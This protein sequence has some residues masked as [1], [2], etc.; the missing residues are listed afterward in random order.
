MATCARRG[1]SDR[2]RRHESARKTRASSAARATTATNVRLPGMV[3]GALLCARR[4]PTRGSSRSNTSQA[5]LIR[6]SPAVVIA[7][8]LE[9]LGL[10]G[11]RPSPTNARP[12]SR[13][14]RSA[15]P[16]GGRVVV[17]VGAYSA[18]DALQLIRSTT[19]CCG[20]RE[21]PASARSRR[22]AHPRRQGSGRSTTCEPT[23]EAAGPKAATGPRVSPRRTRS[24]CATSHA[25]QSNPLPDGGPTA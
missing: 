1:A 17:A 9:T 8:D 11:C 6:R 18:Q 24:R 25:A 5:L 7:K 20:D 3:H 16:P 23:W 15:S 4:T 12:C 21:T 14:T 13:A 19:R 2:P 22:A 10:A